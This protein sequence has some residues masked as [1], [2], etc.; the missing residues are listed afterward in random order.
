[1]IERKTLGL[2]LYT[3]H[4]VA[5]IT[6][7]GVVFNFLSF[8]SLL[9]IFSHEWNTFKP[10]SAAGD[11]TLEDSLVYSSVTSHLRRL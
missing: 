10:Y 4:N 2:T 8:L 11:E 6:E 7:G 9:D 3:V 1:M 5:T